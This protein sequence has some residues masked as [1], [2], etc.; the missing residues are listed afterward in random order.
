VKYIV[1]WSPA[2]EDQ[3]VLVWLAAVDRNAVTEAAHRLEQ[4]LALQPYIGRC[5]DASV[6][7][8]AA[9]HPLGIDF[10]IIEDDKKVRIV[11][12]WSLS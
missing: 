1:I 10:E 12:V 5:R 7:R 3:L 6:N 4:A 2:A 8:T 9:D 11:R